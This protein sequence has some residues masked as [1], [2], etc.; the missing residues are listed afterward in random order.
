[1]CGQWQLSG[2]NDGGIRIV[3]QSEKK[4]GYLEQR[5][6]AFLDG[7]KTVIEEMGAEEFEQQ[8]A[9]LEKKWTEAPK[10]L[11]EETSKHWTHVGR[12]TL[13]FFRSELPLREFS[14]SADFIHTCR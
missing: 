13:D 4:P 11:R 2:Y 1:M 14:V 5:V 6:E 7:M 8:K 12:G 9:G 3:V 10:N